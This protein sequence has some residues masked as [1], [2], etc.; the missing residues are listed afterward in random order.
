MKATCVTIGA[1]I[2]PRMGSEVRNTCINIKD[3]KKTNDFTLESI[4]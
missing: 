2:K 4:I 3:D 1:V